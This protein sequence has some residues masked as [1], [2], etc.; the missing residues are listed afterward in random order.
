MSAL[1]LLASCSL[2][3]AHALVTLARDHLNVRK[4][5][6]EL[7]AN[8]QVTAQSWPETRSVAPI[9]QESVGI[10]PVLAGAC[11]LSVVFTRGNNISAGDGASGSVFPLQEAEGFEAVSH[12]GKVPRWRSYRGPRAGAAGSRLLDGSLFPSHPSTCSSNWL[13]W[14][15]GGWPRSCWSA[16]RWWFCRR[17]GTKRWPCVPWPSS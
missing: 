13:I 7:L 4:Q 11:T 2:G 3:A 14:P 6:G 17:S 12:L 15:Q 8:N 16:A 1:F 10:C 5:F 9:L